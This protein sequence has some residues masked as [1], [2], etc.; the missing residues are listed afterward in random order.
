MNRL[1]ALEQLA[2]VLPTPS[3]LEGYQLGGLPGLGYIGYTSPTP[4]E[5]A[6]YEPVI[7]LILRGR[8]QTTA[9]P[10]TVDFGAGESLVVSHALPVLSQVTEC[11]YLALT[12]SLDV[13]ILRSLMHRIAEPAASPASAESL[14]VDQADEDLVEAL[15]R[16]VRLAADPVEAEVLGPLVL[17]EIHFRLLKARH[18]GMLRALLQADSNASHIHRAIAEIREHFRT[19]LS[20]PRLSARIG[21]SQSAFHRH[22]K[23]ITGT[24]PLQY[25]K[26]MR[27]QEARRLISAEGYS[28]SRAASTV[29]YASPT[30]FSREFSREFGAPPS[31]LASAV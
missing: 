1:E 9:G 2:H 26:I 27:L 15:L 11:P 19:T 29:G 18:G 6:M 24:T 25:Q 14:S 4:L 21:M 8:K 7:C 5:G 16:Y 23:S 10:V 3:E 20:I 17:R 31:R 12:L 28:I 30:Q 13:G 22:F